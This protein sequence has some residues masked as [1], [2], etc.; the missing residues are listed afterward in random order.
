MT[1]L[2]GF[3]IPKIYVTQSICKGPTVTEIAL[4]CL[5]TGTILFSVSANGGNA[6]ESVTLVT[7]TRKVHI[8]STSG[9][10][11][12]FM[13]IGESGAIIAS[14]NETTGEFDEPGLKIEITGYT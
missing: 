4:T 10:D 12:R 13:A 5:Y 7:A 11:V 6:W 2:G 8:F 3:T 14:T 9:T 1:V